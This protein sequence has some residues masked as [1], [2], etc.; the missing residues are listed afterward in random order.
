MKVV[1]DLGRVLLRWR[2]EQV[3]RLALPQRATDDTSAAH[4][5][6]QVFQS[7]GGDWGDFDRGTVTPADLVQRIARRTGLAADEVQMVVEAAPLELQPLPD[8]V[9]LLQ[10][11]HAAGV[12]LFYLSNMPAPFADHLEHSL[13]VMRLFN[14]GVFSGRVHHNK[15]EP[16][17]FRLAQRRF[18]V[19]A[20]EIVFLDDHEP[21]VVAAR[22]MGWQA[23]VFTNAAQAEADL[24]SLGLLQSV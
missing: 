1:F 24:R 16:E 23:F 2:P 5:A 10:R 12:R 14:D 21:N 17:I 22:A 9:A 15:P 19:P 3:L 6:Q 20:Q 13:P 11:L 18:G 4:W 8:T 7:Y